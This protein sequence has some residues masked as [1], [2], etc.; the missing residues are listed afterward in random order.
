MQVLVAEDE[1]AIRISI[2]DWLEDAGYS[3][4]AASSGDEALRLIEGPDRVDLIVTDI[5]M[6][7]A[8]GLE[9]AR[10]ARVHNPQ[11]PVLFV[12]GRVDC[13]GSS[14]QIPVPHRFLAK[15]FRL[16][17]LSMLIVEML[18]GAQ[19]VSGSGGEFASLRLRSGEVS[20]RPT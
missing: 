14:P 20:P 13:L 5:N 19:A 12:S 6:P 3:V 16:A 8:D 9:V 2:V 7:G 18:G 11:V 15:P 10:E 4:I 17:A 1:P